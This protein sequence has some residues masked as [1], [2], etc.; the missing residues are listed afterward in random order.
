VKKS[1]FLTIILFVSGGIIAVLFLFYILKIELTQSIS[2]AVLS[3]TGL[4]IFIQA[5]ATKKMTAYQTMPAVDVN[6]IYDSD[7]EK[8]YF[9]FSNS[10]NIPA[11]VL[12]KSKIGKIKKNIGP[13]RIPPNNPLY[14]VRKTATSFDFFSENRTH[15]EVE[16]VLNITVTSALD[17]NQIKIRFTKSYKFDEDKSRW[18]E[19]SWGYPDPPFPSLRN[20]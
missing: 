17:D 18:N 14:Q 8:T 13:L 11:F 20:Q 9:W 1:S 19:T 3:V 7:Q 12:I 6:M 10:S 4:A 2:I 16:A 5:L 15:E